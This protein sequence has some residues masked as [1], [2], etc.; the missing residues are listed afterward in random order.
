MVDLPKC[1]R[2][3]RAQPLL[4]IVR[5]TLNDIRSFAKK[6][7]TPEI[8]RICPYEPGEDARTV[9]LLTKE[10]KNTAPATL[11]KKLLALR[12]LSTQYEIWLG[13][14]SEPATVNFH[15]PDNLGLRPTFLLE[16][17]LPNTPLAR[18]W[19][20]TGQKLLR[21]ER[22][23]GFQGIS[24]VFIFVLARFPHFYESEVTNAICL[25][26]N[27]AYPEIIWLAIR[28]TPEL[29]DYQDYYT[30]KME[31]LSAVSPTSPQ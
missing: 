5:N 23:V 30:F 1:R 26:K 28:V 13:Q 8:T 19:L 25:L 2:V 14:K 4:D 22:E 7:Q 11:F 31:S 29:I 27:G 21:I 10:G 15:L 9:C 6:D 17:N 24:F 12:Y 18:K 3:S 20:E 16:Q